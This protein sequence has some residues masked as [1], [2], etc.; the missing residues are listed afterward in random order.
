MKHNLILI[1]TA[2]LLAPLAA[3][4]AAAQTPQQPLVGAIRWDAWTGGDVTV[5]VERYHQQP[6]D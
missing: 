4:Q 6:P 1:L 5:Q 2:Q 3:P